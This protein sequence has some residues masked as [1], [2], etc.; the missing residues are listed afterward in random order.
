MAL[1]DILRSIRAGADAEV[2]E[3]EAACAKEVA[4]IV[5]QADD[6]AIRAEQ[7]AATS[8]DRAAE[9][10]ATRIVD[11]ARLEARREAL[12]S[13]EV[14]YQESLDAMRGRLGTIRKTDAYPGIFARLLDEALGVI[15][16]ARRLSVDPADAELAQALL[17]DRGLHH[18]DVEP[19]TACAGGLD[20]STD[21]DR[22]VRNTF[23]SRLER[24]DGRLRRLVAARLPDGITT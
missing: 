21:H 14:A 18:I 19:T 3:L 5:A 15:P 24:A 8:R 6:E 22:T 12:G 9:R 23:E 2:A 10:E 13:V 4:A 20:L 1:D 17:T 7:D 11:R 16:R